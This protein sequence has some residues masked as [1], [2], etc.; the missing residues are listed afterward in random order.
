MDNDDMNNLDDDRD[1]NEENEKLYQDLI[2]HSKRKYD[3]YWDINNPV[4]KV[5][6]IVLLAIGIIGAIYYLIVWLTM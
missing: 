1:V 4:V 3:D 6:L 5:I 2:E